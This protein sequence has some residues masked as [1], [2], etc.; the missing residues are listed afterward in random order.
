VRSLGFERD[1]PLEM[2]LRATS[3]DPKESTFSCLMDSDS[4][5]SDA[6]TKTAAA[7][8]EARQRSS[9]ERSMNVVWVADEALNDAVFKRL[10]SHLPQSYEDCR[11]ASGKA[12]GVGELCGL[13]RRWR[14][15]EYGV[16]GTYR[17]HV[18]GAWP[19]SALDANDVY[20]YD[21][22]GDRT[23]RL[24]ALIYLNDD[25]D[26]GATAF[27]NA[28][29]TPG[30]SV[31]A[32]APRQG[33]VLFFPHGD[34]RGSLI[35]EGAAVLKGYKYVVRTEVL[36]KYSNDED[37]DEDEAASS[38]GGAPSHAMR[39]KPQSQGGKSQGGPSGGRPPSQGGA[40]SQGGRPPSANARGAP[41]KK[42]QGQKTNKRQ[43]RT[44][45]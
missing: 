10:G 43:R 12:V 16:G 33:A 29:D 41:S 31:E 37:E 15:Y 21:A 4:D 30:I 20:V 18:D 3:A 23:S 28:P 45:K 1:E 22:F 25:F 8:V 13:N 9:G 17:P 26:G 7:V 38:Q 2:A 36:Y 19:G 24:T 42:K 11:D 6:D 27:Y 32:V 5:D 39:G 14:F 40:P 34:A 44:C 35:H